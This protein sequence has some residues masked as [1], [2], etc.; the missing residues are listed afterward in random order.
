[1]SS[2]FN[3]LNI[4]RLG[5]LA[6]QYT[7]S[8]LGNNIANV[9]T[10]GYT[11]RRVV[12]TANTPVELGTMSFGTGVKVD[13]VQRIR[14]TF[15]DVY[16][17][18]EMGTLGTLD[19]S[20]ATYKQ[21]EVIFNA[22]SDQGGTISTKLAEFWDAWQTLS[23]EPENAAMREAVVNGG[24]S[25]ASTFKYMRERLA[26]L[27]TDLN[28]AVSSSVDEINTLAGEL[29]ELNEQIIS[30]ESEPHTANDLRDRRDL[31]LDRL[32][33][34]AGVTVRDFGD[35]E[36]AVFINGSLLVSG[37]TVRELETV[38][39]GEGLYDV[40][41]ADTGDAVD[42]S[43]GELK[44]LLDGRDTTIPS[45][46]D[47]IDALATQ[48]IKEVNRL[49]SQGNGL[50]RYTT[51]TSGVAVTDPDAALGSASGLPFDD[52]IQSGSFW[53][54]VYDADGNLLEENEITITAGVSTLNS[55][56]AE[57]GLDFAGNG[58]LDASVANG[59]LTI[60]LGAGAPAG[61]TF[62]FVKSDGTG[63]TSGFLMA[64]EIN[65]FFAGSD[66][67]TIDVSSV[68]QD[69]A[70]VL[71]TASSTAPGDNTI[72]L[73]I[74]NL[75]SESF[76]IGTDSEARTF[77]EY[78]ENTVSTLGIE[79]AREGSLLGNQENIVAAFKEQRES[80]SG[81]NL[82]EELAQL[83]SV[84]HAYAAAARYI[85]T[86]DSMLDTLLSIG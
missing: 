21:I 34:L 52:E 19:K 71:A 55:V 31:I 46:I 49:H 5:L 26:D 62:S 15:L 30:S 11:R 63:D 53:L 72:A 16:L 58:Y 45:Y 59:E 51:A 43:A 38:V 32:S 44:G 10:E 2:I 3:G 23:T 9:N 86:I 6:Q 22:L 80:N 54:A 7:M 33:E 37:T 20:N 50:V 42:P 73:A 66:A 70:D 13:D 60:G 75:R 84:E 17:R 28:T 24:L 27:R 1:M 12:L 25:L 48:I 81:V 82:D 8:V 47:R 4:G 36:M 76:V 83:I 79:S 85:G 69:N 41:W 65:T 29:Q 64:D 68:I 39:N 18:N 35:G 78:Y 77:D 67:A 57:I 14:D 74:G 61:A 56:A 40:Q